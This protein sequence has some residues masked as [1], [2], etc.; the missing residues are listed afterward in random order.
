MRIH[1]SVCAS[2][3]FPQLRRSTIALEKIYVRSDSRL[4]VIDVQAVAVIIDDCPGAGNVPFLSTS[5]ITGKQL[6]FV[7]INLLIPLVIQTLTGNTDNS[8]T[9][10]SSTIAWAGAYYYRNRFTD[11]RPSTLATQCIARATGS[12]KFGGDPGSSLGALGATGVE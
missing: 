10:I 8:S 12:R 9:G 5:C 2:I 11:R 1:Y 3:Y 4:V 6:N 7:V